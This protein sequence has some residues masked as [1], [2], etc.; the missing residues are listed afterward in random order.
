MC[1][2]LGIFGASPGRINAQRAKAEA[3]GFGGRSWETEECTP[4]V[5]W[6]G[7]GSKSEGESLD[8][9]L[10]DGELSG[11]QWRRKIRHRAIY[12]CGSN[13]GVPLP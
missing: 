2:Q 9:R 1:K 5:G 4:R 3:R 10:D 12:M 6:R 7:R 13:A 11:G 8:A